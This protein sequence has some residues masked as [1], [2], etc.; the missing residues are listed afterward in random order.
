MSSE[1]SDHPRLTT[2]RTHLG[3]ERP[4][5]RLVRA[6]G[7]R[8]WVQLDVEPEGR[9][10]AGAD[11]IIALGNA[12]ALAAGA[13]VLAAPGEPSARPL[14]RILELSVNLFRD[15]SRGRLTAEAELTYRGRTT[16][17]VDVRVRDEHEKLVAA[18]VVTQLAPAGDVPAR[19]AS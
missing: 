10:D 1:R 2:D 3:P 6:H 16:L 18:L 11:A 13:S 12:A 9:P 15:G 5:L 17:I 8:A 4:G 14:P 19:L 7:G